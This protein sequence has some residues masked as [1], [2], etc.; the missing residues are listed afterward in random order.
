LLD[1]AFV[2]P[3]L[4]I[5]EEPSQ[6]IGIHYP[7]HRHPFRADETISAKRR[8]CYH[9]RVREIFSERKT[10]TQGQ[11]SPDWGADVAVSEESSEIQVVQGVEGCDEWGGR[12][13]DIK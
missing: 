5:F 7:Y 12:V 8:G 13:R 10:V 11:E 3:C 2:Q 4:L 9:P 1:V 6:K